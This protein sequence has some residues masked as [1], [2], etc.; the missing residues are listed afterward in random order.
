VLEP[1][2]PDATLLL[3]DLQ[4]AIDDPSWAAAGPR[5]N[6]EAEHTVL[7]LLERWRSTGRPIVHIR[8]DSREPASS[9]RPGQPGN[10][11]KPG[12]APRGEE[13]V[14]AKRAG[15]AFVGTALDTLLRTRRG[16]VVVAGVITNNSVES[17]VRAAGDLRYRVLLVEDGC[18]TFARRD[19]SGHLRTAQE[20]HDLSLANLDG[21]YCTVVT[22]AEILRAAEPVA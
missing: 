20:V 16:P 14:I 4:Q 21:E 13:T 8:H 6:P 15:S 2:G 7:R 19:R 11:F 12:L 18:F 9:Y 1:L 22:A 5:N 3:I 17:T 10:A